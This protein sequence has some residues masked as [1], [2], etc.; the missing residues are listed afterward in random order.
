[1]HDNPEQPLHAQAITERGAL[2]GHQEAVHAGVSPSRLSVSSH[3]LSSHQRGGT[4]LPQIDE[5][6][7]YRESE[8][9]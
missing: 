6:G 2:E 1:M 5:A 3:E 9:V 8:G 4:C 7:H